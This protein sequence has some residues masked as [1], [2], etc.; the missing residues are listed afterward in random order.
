MSFH[1]V[2]PA[3]EQALAS[4][5]ATT[6]DELEAALAR[7]VAAFDTWSQHSVAER[8]APLRRAG[9]L[10]RERANVLAR[11]LALE[12]GKP[13]DQGEAEI[14]KCALVCDFYAEHAA[15]F[16]ADEPTLLAGATVVPRPLGPILAIMP[17]NFPAWQAFRFFAPTLAA[18]NV[19]LLKHA[20]NVQGCAEDLVALLADAGF[21][22]GVA[23]NIRVP[24]AEIEALI[25]R[26]EVRAVTLTGSTAAGRAVARAAGTALKKCVLELGGCDAAVILEDADL[27]RA[28]EE[29]V[30]S[31]LI[32]S[33]QS[34]IATKRCIVVDAVRD[35]FT[36]R[37]VERMGEMR[38]A[39][40]LGESP[41]ELGPLA[42]EDLRDALHDQVER[43]CRA[44]GELL[45]GGRVPPGRGWFYPPTVIADFAARSPVSSEETF[46]PV[47]TLIGARDATEAIGRANATSYGLGASIYT[48]DVERGS[49]IA[50]TQLEAGSA[51]VNGFV[52]S[53]PRVP[54]GGIGDSGFGRELGRAGI[55]EFV[56]RK[57]VVVLDG[58]PSTRK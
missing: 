54:F 36:A 6:P 30:T 51:F 21:P 1:S 14:E 25:G 13:L 37:V 16:L 39:D 41:A 11:Q 57:S 17:W 31:R 43:A 40:P 56:N 19:A 7:A 2:N 12:M 45:L 3:T 4:F 10:L 18:G 53:D 38:C 20:E 8:V 50:R 26:P 48:R 28:V 42:R 15:E 32:N 55:L 58:S 23:Q 35:E 52:R 47:L 49:Q 22:A 33:G 34:C 24:V 9:E 5:P 29:C 44:G 27:D 46:G